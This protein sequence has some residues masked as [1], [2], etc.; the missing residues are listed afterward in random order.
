[1]PGLPYGYYLHLAE[2]GKNFGSSLSRA[3]LDSI[4][5]CFSY[6]LAGCCVSLN[7]CNKLKNAI[8]KMAFAE[9]HGTRIFDQILASGGL[10]HIAENIFDQLD[11]ETLANCEEVSPIWRQFIVN[12]G[13]KLWKRQYLEKLAK[14]G[15]DAHRLIKSNPKLFQFDLQADQGNFQILP[16][17]G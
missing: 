7:F 11:G 2:A 14:P 8:E 9:D 1:L 4:T 6:C 16:D 12:N 17:I 13:V 5:T 15:S 3:R 10:A